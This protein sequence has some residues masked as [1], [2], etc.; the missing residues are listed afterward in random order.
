MHRR[1]DP[2]MARNTSLWLFAIFAACGDGNRKPPIAKPVASAPVVV[3]SS[4][5]D[6]EPPA[7]PVA[8]RCPQRFLV[9]AKPSNV[10]VTLRRTGCYG[11][12]P[13]YEVAISR[14]GLVEYVGTEHVRDCAGTGHIDE[15]KLADITRLM[16]R[17]HYFA[18]RDKYTQHDESDAST[19]YTSYSPDGHEPKSIAHYLGDDSAPE[20]LSDIESGIGRIINIEK[21]I[22]TEAERSKLSTESW[23]K[24][25]RP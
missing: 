16:E 19:V 12:C 9:P 22:G 17:D 10:L 7:P 11:S 1:V 15:G 21:W 6:R 14:D 13:V 4:I 20:A 23:P 24:T 5:R 25:S 18:L 2:V 8:A 3:P